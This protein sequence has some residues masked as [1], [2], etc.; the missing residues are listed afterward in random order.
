MIDT[1]LELVLASLHTL[2]DSSIEAIGTL[3]HIGIDIPVAI[4]GSN[5]AVD[6]LSCLGLSGLDDINVNILCLRVEGNCYLVLCSLF[7]VE[8]EVLSR[9]FLTPSMALDNLELVV[10]ALLQ[11]D[12]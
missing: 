8:A 7:D 11:H 4:Y 5:N 10:C 6:V 9:I 12:I 1:Y 3:S 2:K